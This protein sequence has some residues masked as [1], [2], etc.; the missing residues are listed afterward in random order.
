MQTFLPLPQVCL[1]VAG[2]IGL[3][4]LSKPEGIQDVL[5]YAV[6]F[7]PNEFPIEELKRIQREAPAVTIVDPQPAANDPSGRNSSDSSTTKNVINGAAAGL[8]GYWTFL[9][10]TIGQTVPKVNSKL[11]SKPVIVIAGIAGISIV[12]G[13]VYYVFFRSPHNP[14]GSSQ[15]ASAFPSS[16]STPGTGGPGGPDGPDEPPSDDESSADESP[17]ELDREIRIPK[18]IMEDII[19]KNGQSIW[20]KFQQKL[21]REKIGEVWRDPRGDFRIDA[22]SVVSESPQYKTWNLQVNRHP[23][24]PAVKNLL[25]KL[26]HGTHEKLFWGLWNIKNP[27]Q[28]DEW[29]KGIMDAFL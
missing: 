28:Y 7:R 10:N 19:N 4:E 11:K 27:P 5:K 1:T 20:Q 24:S 13:T 15:Q 14:Q 26:P 9:K 22:G 25:K 18:K 6:P 16:Q 3:I 17:P 29:V 2:S 23:P 12:G 8:A 21:T